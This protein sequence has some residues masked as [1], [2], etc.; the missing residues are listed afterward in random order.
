M[1][2]LLSK[3]FGGSALKSLK[4]KTVKKLSTSRFVFGIKHPD[5][6]PIWRVTGCPD[7]YVKTQC[8]CSNHTI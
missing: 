4:K 6:P 2:T 7:K 5:V 3:D 8:N 1:K